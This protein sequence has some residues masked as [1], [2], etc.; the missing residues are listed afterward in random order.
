MMERTSCV[1]NPVDTVSVVRLS[2]SSVECLEGKASDDSQLIGQFELN[3]KRSYLARGPALEV[4]NPCN[5]S[6]QAAWRFRAEGQPVIT[7]VCE[8]SLEPGKNLLVVGLRIDSGEGLVALFDPV[9]S[10]VFKAIKFPKQITAL[11]GVGS[12]LEGDEAALLGGIVASFAGC[13]AVGTHGGLVYL[14]D[15][16]VDDENEEFSEYQPSSIKVVKAH[17]GQSAEQERYAAKS[18]RKHLCV[19]LG[20]AD[21]ARGSFKYYTSANDRPAAHVY[22]SE[23]YVSSLKFLKVCNCLAVGYS[24]GGFQLF[25]L[26]SLSLML[27]STIEVNAPV[28]HFAFLEPENDPLPC[29]FLWAASEESPKQRLPATLTMYQLFFS[30]KSSPDEGGPSQ[31]QGLTGMN[32][33]F[34]HHLVSPSVNLPASES[35]LTSRVI[36]LASL[37]EN[38]PGGPRLPSEDDNVRIRDMTMMMCVWECSPRDHTSPPDTFLGIFDINHWYNAQ[39]P[40]EIRNSR[41]SGLSGICPYFTFMSLNP[42]LGS[43]PDAVLHT[44]IDL[45]SLSR[46]CLG[47]HP[48]P[49]N[50]YWPS[51]VSFSAKCLTATSVVRCRFLSLQQ[52]V[53]D[54]MCKHGAAALIDPAQYIGLSWQAGLLQGMLVDNPLMQDIHVQRTG[55]LGIA[56]QFNAPSFLVSCA[57]TLATGALSRSGVSLRMLADWALTEIRNHK[58][59]IDDLSLPLL[60]GS[61]QL[62]QRQLTAIDFH[63]VC[64]QHLTT[65][66]RVLIDKAPSSTTQEGLKSLN[67]T[68]EACSLLSQHAL[69]MVWL[70]AHKLLPEVSEPD[71]DG[72]GFVYPYE[73]LLQIH[74]QCQEA[75]ASNGQQLLMIDLLLERWQGPIDSI[76][77]AVASGTGSYPPP[78]FHALLN[79]F[80]VVRQVPAQ[81]HS[82]VIFYLLLDIALIFAPSSDDLDKDAW[83]TL[84]QRYAQA[85]GMD[86]QAVSVL[87]GLWA[88]DR[89]DFDLALNLLTQPGSKVS[90]IPG[91]EH[92]ILQAF[93]FAGQSKLAA[94]YLQRVPVS[95]ANVQHIHLSL[96]TLISNGLVAEAFDYQ[97]RASAPG[98]TDLFT[99]MLDCCQSHR[100]LHKLSQL[101]LTDD[102]EHVWVEFLENSDS[103]PLTELLVMFYLQRARYVE[104]I[105]LNDKLLAISDYADSE[106]RD[107]AIVREAIVQGYC[108][109]LP[110]VQHQ[111][112]T[113]QTR[114]PSKSK[115]ADIC[116]VPLSMTISQSSASGKPL[117]E[118]HL[119]TMAMQKI[120]E[121]RAEP[122]VEAT[123][124]KKRKPTGVQASP[125]IGTPRINSHKSRL[126]DPAP[127]LCASPVVNLADEEPPQLADV[128]MDNLGPH[129]A[130]ASAISASWQ[131]PSTA[132]SFMD[133]STVP[134]PGSVNL[135][136][137]VQHSFA[138]RSAMISPGS[139]LKPLEIPTGPGDASLSTIPSTPHSI[140]KVRHVS[141]QER[142]SSVTLSPPRSP[143]RSD[144]EQADLL[145]HRQLPLSRLI[146]E[147]F[148]LAT[149]PSVV[150]RP[151][152]PRRRAEQS[153]A[154]TPRR[155]R[156]AGVEDEDEEEEEDD[157]EKEQGASDSPKAQYNNAEEQGED[158][159]VEDDEYDG[160]LLSRSRP[161]I[162][163]SALDDRTQSS[164]GIVAAASSA[165][166]H[167]ARVASSTAAAAA[168]TAM[169]TPMDESDDDDD[170]EDFLSAEEDFTSSPTTLSPYGQRRSP[171]AS[172]LTSQGNAA[173][174]SP[175]ASPSQH[176]EEEA[177]EPATSSPSASPASKS[178][179]V[180]EDSAKSSVDDNDDW[181]ASRRATR[182]QSPRRVASQGTKVVVRRSSRSRKTQETA[183]AGAATGSGS[184]V[185]R[186]NVSA[187]M[188]SL[189]RAT[190]SDRSD[191]STTEEEQRS[192]MMD[193][194]DASE[195]VPGAVAATSSLVAPPAQ[196]SP[197]RPSATQGSSS[198]ASPTS[199]PARSPT[200]STTA[201][202]PTHRSKPVSP[203]RVLHSLNLT[204]TSPHRPV[205][206]SPTA[207]LRRS[208]RRSFPTSASIAPAPVTPSAASAEGMTASSSVSDDI[209]PTF[210]FTPPNTRAT[211]SAEW[212][213]TSATRKSRVSSASKPG[214]D[215]LFSPPWT[216]SRGT[217]TPAS[218]FTLPQDQLV[219]SATA[220]A[221][222]AAPASPHLTSARS[223]K[224]TAAVTSTSTAPAAV[225][226]PPAES[227]DNGPELVS[228]QSLFF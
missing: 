199:S 86:S 146:G 78:N 51:A 1:R 84:A 107:R 132:G 203:G 115:S 145:A 75:L 128:S 96:D 73:T 18:E 122:V 140:L 34:F 106:A 70:A 54:E 77:G 112:A 83:L 189:T 162:G 53:L 57:T 184:D 95:R 52:E 123:P 50:F 61:G 15:L 138:S 144:R 16:R 89:R 11:E 22:E 224:L 134:R 185:A 198:A 178:S 136:T 5:G 38:R 28:T 190:G 29:F 126:I 195:S 137:P 19:Q 175:A 100:L 99:H 207:S 167:H 187:L 188:T 60:D 125:F 227:M 7:A 76:W 139:I 116:P 141:P 74:H 42:V 13:V 194:D 161:T 210:Q 180:S 103:A 155:I 114:M 150:G 12:L 32:C 8:A 113:D 10:R 165:L 49:D 176:D 104:A 67:D 117:T 228:E 59:S 222:A 26:G 87:R 148:H 205:A 149:P 133:M 6:R 48:L 160:G 71:D 213:V 121:A 45:P 58:Q 202:S 186:N 177:A 102:E 212:G 179:S 158:V 69:T 23:V 120:T 151:A 35:G 211:K 196:R 43:S 124:F 156:F 101:P 221:A 39:M 135:G 197:I 91:Q 118:A 85:F 169:S 40:P 9:L 30:S 79:I 105:R 55:L 130:A 164:S 24:I 64:L 111:L 193:D 173:L 143:P 97:R 94:I 92:H 192:E 4:I 47:P 154:E 209:N 27:G 223:L 41:A 170:A 72:V 166:S 62:S 90:L 56:L 88:L 214:P 168:A 93:L 142:A 204:K 153:K 131:V 226:P 183:A 2:S 82:F 44:M 65:L 110:L 217:S 225:A 33:R 157:A 17:T 66:Y 31:Y 174:A 63:A 37:G 127:L 147:E 3:G 163:K 46:C 81:V 208:P 182:Q 21:H 68:Y 152:K 108:K 129:V 80:F 219:A 181:L 159:D 25:D 200:R 216:R 36:A 201:S 20:A 191:R 14:L 119:I 171:S 218:R 220:A 206:T 98:E 215:I 172:P 109:A